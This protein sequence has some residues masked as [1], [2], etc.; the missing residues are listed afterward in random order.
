MSPQTEPALRARETWWRRTGMPLATHT[1]LVAGC[2]AMLFPYLWM[3]G[4]SFKPP[5]ETMLWP[6]RVLPIHWTWANYP[7][8]LDAAPFGLYFLNSLVV[9]V[10]ATLMV[11]GT[12]LLAGFI[13]G[14]YQFPGKKLLFLVILAS[15]MFPFETYMIPLYLTM[16]SFGWINTYQGIAAPYLIMSFGIFLMRQHIAHGIPDE[17]VDAARVDGA[18]ELRIFLRVIVPLCSSAI[19]AIGILAFIQAW[20]AFIWPLLMATSKNM[21]LMEI[22]LSTFQFRFTTEYH[23]LCAAA[24]LN[25][26]PM[27]IAFIILR[28]RIMESVALTGLKG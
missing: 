28:R 4:T 5:D 7:K 21:F 8:A 27:L 17:L 14:K 22:G 23:L 15:A 18:S 25:T 19:G 24:V 10:G 26:V 20:S 2:V 3:L 13:F 6:P 12:S 1:V 11:I 16:K 9:S